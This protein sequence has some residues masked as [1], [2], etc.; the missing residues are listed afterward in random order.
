MYLVVKSGLAPT[1]A[2]T[3][4][5]YVSTARKQALPNRPLMHLTPRPLLV[6]SLESCRAHPRLACSVALIL[7]TVV[8]AADYAAGDRIPLMACYLPSVTIITWSC[9]AS[10]GT[11]FATICA[12]VWLV[13]DFLGLPGAELAEEELWHAGSHMIFFQVIVMT[14]ARLKTVYDQE[15]QN[16]RTDGLTKLLNAKA[17]RER[18]DEEIARSQRRRATVSVAFVDCDDFKAVNDTYGHAE[19]DRLLRTI[20]NEMRESVRKFDVLARMGGD[21]FAILLPDTDADDA[22]LVIR[23]MQEQLSA[24]MARNDWPVTFS[25]GVAVHEA[26]PSCAEELIRGA[27]SLMY[28]V[29]HQDK[30]GI[31][32]HLVA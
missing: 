3:F 26:P 29:K 10:A 2:T 18:A 30:N 5:Y 28:M 27:D 1:P 13:D 21:E 9:S 17:F 8:A 23:R 31:L 16:A 11:A 7:A 22:D 20:A 14:L 19:G 25:I 6:K 24:A 15:H 32:L 12:T 4:A